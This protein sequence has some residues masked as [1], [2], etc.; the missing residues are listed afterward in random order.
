ML[1]V[2][3]QALKGT[4]LFTVVSVMS[5]LLVFLLSALVLATS[6]NNRAHKSY[7]TSQTQYTARAA[8]DSV[9]KAIGGS[10][11]F[12]DSIDA[13]SSSNK[14]PMNVSINF[15]SSA[16]SMGRLQSVTVEWVGNKQY[17][18]NS[19]MKWETKDLLRITAIANLA[20]ERSTCSSYILKDPPMSGTTT[21]G[22]AGFVTAGGASTDNHT[23]AFGG[24]FLNI[25]ECVEDPS[26]AT[27]TPY[28]TLTYDPLTKN[29]LTHD[30]FSLGNAQ[31]IEADCVVNGNLHVNS[32]ADF[33]FPN[34]GT[35]VAV[36]GDFT[37][38]NGK[39]RFISENVKNGM[40]LEYNKVPYFYVDGTINANNGLHLGD[41][42]FPMN[43]FCGS[44]N[45]SKFQ[46][47]GDL[48]CMDSNGI[49]NLSGNGSESKLASWTE[50]LLNKTV[51]KNPITHTYGNIYSKGDLVLDVQNGLTIDGDVRVVGNLTIKNGITIKGNVVVGKKLTVS[52]NARVDL[53]VSAGKKLYTDTPPDVQ[54]DNNLYIAG[55]KYA[56]ASAFDPN[57]KEVTNIV[58]PS[59]NIVKPNYEKV[60]NIP[61]YY[62]YVVQNNL[63]LFGED[64]TGQVN[65]YYKYVNY[66]PSQPYDP[67]LGAANVS[68]ID[69]TVA[70]TDA[71]P[72][73]IKG[74]Y[75]LIDADNKN[76]PVSPTD[77]SDTQTSA[78]FQYYEISNPNRT[79]AVDPSIATTIKPEY[80]TIAAMDGVTDTNVP[81]TLDKTYY[82]ASGAIIPASM[83][84][85][86]VSAYPRA[87][88][89]D[90][91]RNSNAIY[92]PE[93]ER[94]VILGMKQVNGYDTTGNYTL[95]PVT[96]TQIVKSMK[97][98]S[99]SAVN[100]YSSAKYAIPSTYQADVN[101]N[102]YTIDN[103]TAGADQGCILKDS[104]G[105][106]VGTKT[107]PIT[108]SCTIKCNGESFNTEVYFSPN[109]GAEIW[110]KIDGKINL[111][112]DRGSIGKFIFVDQ[113]I[114]DADPSKTSPKLS[115]T[116]LNF[117]LTKNSSIGMNYGQ[118][119]TTTLKS[120]LEKN[121]T[122]SINNYS[123]ATP[124]GATEINSPQLF[125]Y[126]E[127]GTSKTDV[128]AK[129]D[130]QNSALLTGHIK[131]AYLDASITNVSTFPYNSDIY[132]NG[133]KITGY[134]NN[135]ADHNTGSKGRFKVDS[136]DE[137][138]TQQFPI[139]GSMNVGKGSFGN[140]WTLLY[141]D[142]NK[143]GGTPSITPSGNHWYLVTYYDQY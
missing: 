72:E 61:L 67:A 56:T 47:N 34:P 96:D 29:Y 82:N 20:G 48:Y 35:G 9:F 110:V 63:G 136:N 11:D 62:K 76:V 111:N 44:I 58:H 80:K 108:K 24:T 107:N 90:A 102:I 40:S 114:N 42:S 54:A 13:L 6:A 57:C 138:N 113:N 41:G 7:T 135:S 112:A 69:G 3:K 53:G 77:P 101:A 31:V 32:A 123:L 21:G 27:Q 93:M 51:S 141:V 94:L 65:L 84:Y 33:V 16:A 97:D 103:I 143:G 45:A 121:A 88:Y 132:Y 26:N 95:L 66:D 28:D 79:E 105:S 19:K 133:I 98:I 92:P 99:K 134:N 89:I 83:A 25:R 4:V 130:M 87:A 118:I 22:G 17:Y 139:I 18:N 55:N 104:A 81:T 12:A 100:P 120:L 8:V 86:T 129:I 106:R 1:R 117:F 39:E 70:L 46:I 14:G 131:A 85:V 10:Q 64:A 30:N 60:Y 126:S 2:K 140:D 5:L 73:I 59:E 119:I 128:T 52:T 43:T 125:I 38:D 122:I 49:S 37:T 137:V 109:D 142:P 71:D 124:T 50:S 91:E 115:S 75:K 74:I 116:K 15:D 36:W 78:E 68:T 127:K 23:S